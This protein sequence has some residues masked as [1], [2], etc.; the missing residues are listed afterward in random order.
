VTCFAT[1]L[2]VFWFV[3]WFIALGLFNIPPSS[4]D[5]KEKELKR[6]ER[7]VKS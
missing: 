6:L 4:E 3:K 5:S 7:H 2:T 1:V